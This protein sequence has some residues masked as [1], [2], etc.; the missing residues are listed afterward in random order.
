MDGWME[1]GK[2]ERN[3]S[4]AKERQNGL[5]KNDCCSHLPRIRVTGE[6]E[7]EGDDGGS[8]Q[9]GEDTGN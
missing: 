8:S 1:R 5:Q 4:T 6:G 9:G 3:K 2:I 7:D